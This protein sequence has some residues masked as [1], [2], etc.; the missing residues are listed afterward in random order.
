MSIPSLADLRRKQLYGQTADGNADEFTNCD[1]E[2]LTMAT[3]TVSL[4]DIELALK[5]RRI[6]IWL[7]DRRYVSRTFR[8]EQTDLGV[9][10][11]IDSTQA[12]EARQFADQFG[13][14]AVLHGRKNGV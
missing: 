7:D 4:G 2:I 10:V 5:L 11:H 1:T 13:G 14:R 12:D 3:V 6:R 8:Y 9:A